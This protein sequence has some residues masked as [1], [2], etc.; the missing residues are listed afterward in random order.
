MCIRD[1]ASS[2]RAEVEAWFRQRAGLRVTVPDYSPAGIR[3]IGGR[4]ADAHERQA[5][6]LLYEKGRNLI[7]LFAFPGQGL[8]LTSGGWARVG[9]GR[10]YV[11]KVNGAE[12]VVWTQ[13]PLAYALVSSLD[14]EALLE[15]ADT[16]WRLVGS[17]PLPG[18]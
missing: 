4:L 17:R 14:R 18:A 11:A 16:V 2:D 7:S 15:C 13:G 6:Y 8:A 3:L 10:F 5:A 9:D 1:R 12:V